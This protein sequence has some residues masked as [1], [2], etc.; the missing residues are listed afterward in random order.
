[1]SVPFVNMML[2]RSQPIPA[3]AVV[4]NTNTRSG[5]G[6]SNGVVTGL[7]PDLIWTKR[8]DTTSNHIL[9]DKVRGVNSQ[10]SSNLAAAQTALTTAHTAFN[11]N[12]FTVGTDTAVNATGDSY[13][14]WSFKEA[15]NFFDIVS[16]AGTGSSKT[17]AH[18]LGVPPGLMLVKNLNV[19]GQ[20]WVVY[21]RSPGSTQYLILN[22]PGSSASLEIIWGNTDPTSSVFT[23]GT[24][25]AVNGNGNSYIAYLFAHDPSGVIQCGQY[26]GNGSATGPVVNL[27][28]DPQYLLI[29][30]STG[31]GAW[32]IFDAARG[33]GAADPYMDANTTSVEVTGSNVVD[34][35]GSGFQLKSTNTGFNA[36]GSTYIY[37][38]IK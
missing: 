36:S 18:N 25:N 37:M 34:V 27:G 28:W 24:D 11:A 7:N 17:V 3:V 8:R 12:G 13:V 10:L 32:Y 19:A 31:T 14:D 20:P 4:F 9:T 21:H 33:L 38:A 5:T 30:R 23:V 2:L 29:K 35:T 15:A 22:S 16:Y 26:T 1:M 6:S